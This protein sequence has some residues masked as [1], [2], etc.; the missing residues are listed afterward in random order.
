MVDRIKFSVDNCVISEEILNKKFFKK[1]TTKNGSV[2]LFKN[3]FN[4]EEEDEDE[5]EPVKYT[6][7]QK[8]KKF[9]YV[10]YY[11]YKKAKK[12]PNNEYEIKTELVVHRNIRKEF[13]DEGK[14][15]DLKY[16]NF[17]KVLENIKI[18]FDLKDKDLWNSR[19]TKLEL[20]A[21]LRFKKNM[22]G[23]LS[24]FDSF[25]GLTE[26]NIYGND[27]I[28]F[29]GENYSVSIY[30]KLE[31]MSKNGELFKESKNKIK[32][33]DKVAKNNYFLRIELKIEKVS[34]FYRSEFKNKINRLTHIRDNWNYL[35]T[36]L[37]GLYSQIN[38]IDVLSPEIE[39]LISGEERTPMNNFLKFKGM[40]SIGTDS[41][42]NQILPLMKKD[43]LSTFRKEYRKFYNDFER[44]FRL[45]Y[46]TEFSAKLEDRIDSLKKES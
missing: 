14:T 1:M 38:Y 11:T 25:N 34:G 13:F 20:G 32:L 45:D 44:K 12:L 3:N 40:Q 7:N 24:C 43:K 2:Y 23:I 21:T 28:A 42:F 5:N 15:N 18:E 8:F 37:Y 29:I 16:D 9:F 6:Y 30:D 19:V 17:L 46:E 39:F 31:R 35:G 36:A 10:K 26:K 33:K 22:R 27:G 41:F 4:E